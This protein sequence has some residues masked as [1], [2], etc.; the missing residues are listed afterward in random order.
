VEGVILSFP[1]WL[2][3]EGWKHEWPPADPTQ[4]CQNPLDG[5]LC[6]KKAHKVDLLRW[7]TNTKLESMCKPCWEDWRKTRPSQ[8]IRTG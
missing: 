7:N 1:H 3:Q 5:H 4:Y 2:N 8:G 6:L